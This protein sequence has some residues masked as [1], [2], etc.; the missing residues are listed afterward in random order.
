MVPLLWQSSQ[1]DVTNIGSQLAEAFCSKSAVLTKDISRQ[2]SP[3]FVV[4][5]LTS[6]GAGKFSKK[7]FHLP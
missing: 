3:P 6:M 7:S 5:V 4:N 2:C 1:A